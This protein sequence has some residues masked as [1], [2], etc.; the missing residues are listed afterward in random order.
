MCRCLQ[1]LI[2]VACSPSLTAMADDPG[3]YRICGR[4]VRPDGEAF[5]NPRPVVVLN[6]AA[7]PVSHQTVAAADGNFAFERLSAGVY[8]LVAAVPGVPPLRKTVEVGPPF[9]DTR[10]AIR[11][12]L[13]LESSSAR[14]QSVSLGELAVPERARD[15]HARSRLRL[16]KSDVKGAIEC[17]KK[18]L[19]LAPQFAAA[20]NDLGAIA[21]RHQDYPQAES[22]FREALRRQPELYPPLVNLG[23]VL[24]SERKIRESLDVNL[25]AVEQNPADPM[26]EAQLGLSYLYVDNEEMALVHLKKAKALDPAHFSYPQLHLM[27][28]YSRRGDRSAAAAEMEEFLRLHPGSRL[29]SSIRRRLENTRELL[30]H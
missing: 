4:V 26:A 12:E 27:E 18:A 14:W 7:V 13:R 19:K 29:A 22:C 24:L 6:S 30:A 10:N 15:E 3:P 20:W 17:L 5:H 1:W 23:N 21:F 28:I 9:A 2:L 16:S 8:T 11:I 25:R